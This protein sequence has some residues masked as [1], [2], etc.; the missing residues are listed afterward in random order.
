M[1]SSQVK[2]QI[3][4]DSRNRFKIA[5]VEVKKLSIITYGFDDPYELV[6]SNPGS[7]YFEINIVQP[8]DKERAPRSKKVRI[9]DGV[10]YFYERNGK[11]DISWMANGLA[12]KNK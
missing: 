1:F 7:N 9:I 8:V 4:V 11:V 5:K 10:A 2:N 3:I 12:K 6:V